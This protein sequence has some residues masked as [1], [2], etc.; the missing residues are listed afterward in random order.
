[1]DLHLLT[2]LVWLPTF[3]EL[4]PARR[5]GSA[6]PRFESTQT[7][8]GEGSSLHCSESS[9]VFANSWVSLCIYLERFVAFDSPTSG[10]MAILVILVFDS[11]L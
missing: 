10:I 11:V 6:S 4:I 5:D 9:P 3:D 2:S 7:T 1:M 8:S